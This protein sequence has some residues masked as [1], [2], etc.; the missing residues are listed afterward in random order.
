MI[1]FINMPFDLFCDDHLFWALSHVEMIR[2]VYNLK[3]IVKWDV[4]NISDTTSSKK[5]ILLQI[6][7][8]IVIMICDNDFGFQS[9]W[10]LVYNQLEDWVTLWLNKYEQYSP[11]LDSIPSPSPM[12]VTQG[13]AFFHPLPPNLSTHLQI[14]YNEN[15]QNNTPP[16][17]MWCTSKTTAFTRVTMK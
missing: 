15:S 3:N 1:Y 5:K 6:K 12:R 7:N 16:M 14:S 4:Q 10:S 17:K 9:K 11:C 8:F 13:P 2:L